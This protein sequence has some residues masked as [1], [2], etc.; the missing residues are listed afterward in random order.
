[1]SPHG[2]WGS[3]KIVDR[4]E[5]LVG[6]IRNA[7]ERGQK[8]EDIKKSFIS[9]GYG[10]EEVNVAAQRSRSG[11]TQPI[12]EQIP[13]PTGQ[14]PI[15]LQKSAPTRIPKQIQSPQTATQVTSVRPKRFSKALVIS[16]IIVSA[17][18]LIG[19]ALFGIY[20]DRIFS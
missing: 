14:R 16:L 19:A 11:G 12:P 18:I 3:F 5:E 17:L 8:I 15:P 20:W 7:L 10:P 4:S 6:G 13:I 2:G 9:A 1:M